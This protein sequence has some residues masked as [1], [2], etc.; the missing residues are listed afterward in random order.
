MLVALQLS[1]FGKKDED[2]F[3]ILACLLCLI[4]NGADPSK[5][6]E[7]SELLFDGVNEEARCQH[8]PFSPA[9]LTEEIIFRYSRQWSPGLLRGWRICYWALHAAE[10][11]WTSGLEE[12]QIPIPMELFDFDITTLTIDPATSDLPESYADWSTTTSYR[13]SFLRPCKIIHSE[14][15]IGVHSLVWGIEKNYFGMNR[16]LA[17]L[18]AAVQAELLTYRRQ[19]EYQPWVSEFF[20]MEMLWNGLQSENRVQIRLVT[21]DMMKPHCKCGKFLCPSPICPTSLDVQAKDF[22]NM[23]CRRGISILEP[24]WQDL[25]Y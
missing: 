3:G 23:K 19:N 13:E 11:E 9:Q 24:I 4:M 6:T 2:L 14:E 1:T 5:T 8:R 17:N 12:E 7:L 22:S 25:V 21:D 10:S 20:D 15:E 18:W 16:E